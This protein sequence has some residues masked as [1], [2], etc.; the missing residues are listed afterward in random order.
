MKAGKELDVLVAEDVMG[1]DLTSDASEE[2]LARSVFSANWGSDGKGNGS[3]IWND[4]KYDKVPLPNGGYNEYGNAG[5]GL[6]L[7]KQRRDMPW[8]NDLEVHVKNWRAKPKEYSTS[9]SAAWEVVE[10][11][12]SKDYDFRCSCI[13]PGFWAEFRHYE[14]PTDM[15]IKDG[16]AASVDPRDGKM[17][18][19]IC[20]AALKAINAPVL[21]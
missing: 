5:Y 8:K 4:V 11:M 3:F 9:I 21:E 13:T 12:E 15:P 19:A 20:L 2:A 17:S 6:L 18:L 1:I 10:K 7:Y 16:G 14:E